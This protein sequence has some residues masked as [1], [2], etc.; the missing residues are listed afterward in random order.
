[1]LDDRQQVC[2]GELPSFLGVQVGEV[3]RALLSELIARDHVPQLVRNER[4]HQLQVVVGALQGHQQRVHLAPA[5]HGASDAL[6]DA[7]TGVAATGTPGGRRIICRVSRV[8]FTEVVQ[9]AISSGRC[10][11]CSRLLAANLGLCRQLLCARKTLLDVSMR[12]SRFVDQQR[13]Q[14]VLEDPHEVV[15]LK[16]GGRLLSQDNLFRRHPS[17]LGGALD[18]HRRRCELCC[19]ALPKNYL[20]ATAE[21]DL[22]PLSHRVC[23]DGL[24]RGDGHEE[25]DLDRHGLD[26]GASKPEGLANLGGWRLPLGVTKLDRQHAAFGHT[27]GLLQHHLHRAA[28]QRLCP[29]EPL[30]RS[31]AGARVARR[32]ASHCG[33]KEGEENGGGS[34][35]ASAWERLGRAA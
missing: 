23:A 32:A 15:F 19:Q 18:I 5:P 22:K 33:G 21:V 2:V 26:G 4:Q 10:R 27:L 8:R 12:V 31:S 7:A 17:G 24:R 6:P 13:V 30:R 34:G 28:P 1:M 3:F 9:L 20:L 29:R 11:R 25:L 14:S 35:W 16:I